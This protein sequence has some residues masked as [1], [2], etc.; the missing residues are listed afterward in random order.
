MNGCNQARQPSNTP[1]NTEYQVS[2]AA[3][4]RLGNRGANDDWYGKE[5]VG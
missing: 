2:E 3:A 5:K 4:F 1:F